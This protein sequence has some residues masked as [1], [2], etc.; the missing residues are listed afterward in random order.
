MEDAY[1]IDSGIPIFMLG[2]E[3]ELKA[4]CAALMEQ[5][6]N[7]TIRGCAS[8]EM[9]Q[10]VAVHRQRVTGNAPRAAREARDVSTGIVILPFDHEVLDL[11]LE[12]M[13]TGQVRRRDAVHAATAAVY[14][15]TKVI[16]ADRDFGAVSGLERIDP[17]ELV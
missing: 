6:L 14:G 7:G 10:E 15:I 2:R 3:H 11:A 16:S 17:R 5:V 4:P 9:V 13:A 1:L 12:L 8:T